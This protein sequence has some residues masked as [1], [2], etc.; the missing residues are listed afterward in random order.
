VKSHLTF[1]SFLILSA[2]V[3]LA[4]LGGLGT[5][6]KSAKIDFANDLTSFQISINSRSSLNTVSQVITREKLVN[7]SFPR[8]LHKPIRNLTKKQPNNFTK[9]IQRSDKINPSR[10]PNLSDSAG[11]LGQSKTVPTG[12]I[13]APKPPYPIRARKLGF[14]GE[15]SLN[16]IIGPN[17]VVKEIAVLKSSG[18]TDCD[19]AA[20]STIKNR[21]RFTPAHL[22]GKPVSSHEKIVVVFQ[23]E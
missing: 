20:L 1:S 8:R 3:H 17:G 11:G 14:E 10:K 5:I 7:S 16:V 4:V 13:F 22:L 21:W 6:Y 19:Q 18:R 9:R 15:V 2:V 12:L 23:L